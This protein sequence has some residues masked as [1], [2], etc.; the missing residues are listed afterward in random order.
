M[1]NNNNFDDYSK[2]LFFKFITDENF[3]KKIFNDIN[4]VNE[5]L[6]KLINE[7]KNKNKEEDYQKIKEEEKNNK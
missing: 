4:E 7:N 3:R 1:D 5:K 2:S 6:E